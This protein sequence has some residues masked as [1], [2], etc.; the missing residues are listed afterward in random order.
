MR[1]SQLLL[2]ALACALFAPAIFADE[3]ADAFASAES[4]YRRAQYKEA[5]AEYQSFQQHFP[6]DWRAEQA[7]LTAAFILH[8][9][10]KDSGKAVAAYQGL[11][12]PKTSAPI[13]RMAKFHMAE[14]YV[15]AG[16]VQKAIATYE[17]LRAG[18]EAPRAKEV[19]R[20]LRMLH[21]AAGDDPGEQLGWGEK[22][23]GKKWRRL[24]K[25][26]V[27]TDSTET[28]EQIPAKQKGK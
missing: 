25:L 4:K 20:A 12:G 24:K 22:L 28:L 19:N 26:V 16:D 13:S 3:A 18:P 6:K 10:I 14:A 8:K 23:R 21:R 5:L 9:K 7:Q 15:R 27:D 2:A 11:T 17:E 1:T